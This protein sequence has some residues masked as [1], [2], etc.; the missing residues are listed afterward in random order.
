MLLAVILLFLTL[1]WRT[2]L[3]PVPRWTFHSIFHK[4]K[5][6]LLCKEREERKKMQYSQTSFTEHSVLQI[7]AQQAGEWELL[8]SCIQAGSTQHPLIQNGFNYFNINPGNVQMDCNN[9]AKLRWS[10]I[11]TQILLAKRKWKEHK[12]NTICQ[13]AYLLRS[14][15]FQMPSCTFHLMWQLLWKLCFWL[16]SR[17]NTYLKSAW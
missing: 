17:I 11:E 1:G 3:I 15:V 16:N 9:Y 8:E 5:K 10:F 6:K 2:T 7:T 4:R 12:F 14:P 13:E